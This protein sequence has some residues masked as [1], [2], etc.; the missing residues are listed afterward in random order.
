LIEFGRFDEAAAGDN[1]WLEIM[2]SDMITWDEF[3]RLWWREK[4]G[5]R[6]WLLKEKGVA[7]E[8]E[9]M[10]S[11]SGVKGVWNR[12]SFEKGEGEGEGR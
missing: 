11:G 3:D 7:V 12:K 2:T 10:V 4:V 9:K 1:N 8:V 5:W 6:V